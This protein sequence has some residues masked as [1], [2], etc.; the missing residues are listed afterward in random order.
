MRSLVSTARESIR[1]ELRDLKVYHLLGQA[2]IYR[3]GTRRDVKS[4]TKLTLPMLARRAMA[5][6]DE[7]I[8]LDAI[9]KSLVAETAPQLVAR[10]G[11][12]TDSASALLV[13]AG[14]NP[15]R[16]RSEAPSPTCAGRHP[17]PIGV[18]VISTTADAGVALS[19]RGR[20]HPI[21]RRCGGSTSR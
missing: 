17:P 13:A 10:V 18:S 7:I 12:G 4:L 21:T 14:D 11:I 15:Q 9:L 19:L 5:L 2:S 1:A 8:E 20:S 16:L 6:E 3:P